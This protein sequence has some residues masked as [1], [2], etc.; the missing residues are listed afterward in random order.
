MRWAERY[1][2]LPFIDHGRNFTGVDCW[3]LVR[4]IMQE[5]CHIDIPSYGE[6]SALD[7]QA[8]AGLVAKEKE[9][10]PWIYVHPTAVKPFDVV[11][12][13]RRR[14]PIH[15]GIMATQ[16]EII[17]IEAKTDS[18]MVPLSHATIKFRRPTFYRHRQLLSHAA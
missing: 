9:I 18:V 13:H 3:G 7:L 1:I 17:H 14:E 2:G 5:E 11:V 16:K 6:T 10:E 8:V 12:M 15:I 4:L